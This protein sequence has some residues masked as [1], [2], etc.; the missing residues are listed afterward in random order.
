MGYSKTEYKRRKK[1][2]LEDSMQSKAVP[3]RNP[4]PEAKSCHF[5][6][7]KVPDTFLAYVWVE[8]HGYQDSKPVRSIRYYHVCP[9][10]ARRLEVGDALAE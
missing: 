5:C 7:R 4:K 1:L 10:C 6:G 3:A 9:S 2:A 8:R